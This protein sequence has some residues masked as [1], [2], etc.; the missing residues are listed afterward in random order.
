MTILLVIMLIT[1]FCAL[2]SG[3]PVAFVLSGVSLIFACIG[4]TLG[5]FDMA[6]LSALPN[7]IYGIMRNDLL[8]SIP[9]FVFMGVM[10][11][12]A[13]IAEELLEGMSLAFGK[14]SSGLGVSVVLVGAILAAST[15]IVGAT[16]VTMG[17]ISLPTMLKA[18]YCSRISSG[19]ICAAGTLG[20]IIP[21]SIVLILLG[22]QISSANQTAQMKMGNLSPDPVSIADL[23]VGA[24]IPGLILVMLYIAWLIIYSKLF[25]DKTPAQKTKKDIRFTDLAKSL[26]PPLLLI[27]IV[28]GSILTGVATATESAAVG[29]VGAIIL[30]FFKKEFNLKNLNEVMR[31]TAK[32]SSMVFTILIGAAIFTL[33]FRGFGGDDVVHSILGDLPGG[34]FTAMLL[35]MVVM[36]LLGF[37]LDFIEIIFVVV[38][39]VAPILLMIG[40]DP[41]WL[42][43]MIAVNLQT[44]FLTPPFGFALFYLRGVAPAS[45]LS[46]DIY[47]GIT[48][49][50]VIQIVVLCLLAGFPSLST[51]LPEV[52]YGKVKA[53]QHQ[54]EVETYD[55]EGSVDF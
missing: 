36:F 38:P 27:L 7:R 42:A 43:I 39:I 55:D 45:V 22:D 46:S 13:K 18:G 10:L 21:P 8:I 6:Y 23:F 28:L 32:V 4:S 47:K 53:A 48:P 5:L 24:L 19:T 29:A 31:S 54:L 9:L 26:L 2:L 1:L 15:G 30:S 40:A 52:V 41:I 12:R 35:T 49:F 20:Q 37:F 33:V 3:F 44:S 51:K 17:L 25:P 16:V 50:V 14:M 11:E 34:L